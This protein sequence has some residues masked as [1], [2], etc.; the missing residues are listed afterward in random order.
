MEKLLYTIIP[1]ATNNS[2]T[3]RVDRAGSS[4]LSYVKNVFLEKKPISDDEF[5]ALTSFI[6]DFEY[7]EYDIVTEWVGSSDPTPY[8]SDGD[9]VKSEIS[10]YDVVIEDG[11]SYGLIKRSPYGEEY[12]IVTCDRLTG[13]IFSFSDSARKSENVSY[14]HDIEIIKRKN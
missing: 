6:C 5:K 10:P 11:K 13:C 1:K 2:I 12:Q 9:H 3:A 8:S 14:S 4:R 7:E